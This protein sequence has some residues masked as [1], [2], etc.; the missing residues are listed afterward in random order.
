MLHQAPDTC[1]CGDR[2]H[3]VAH[4]IFIGA[5]VALAAHDDR[6]AL[7]EVGLVRAE[8][9]KEDAPLLGRRDTAGLG[10]AEVEEHDQDPGPLDVAQELVAQALALCCPLHQAGDVGHDELRAVADATDPDDAEVRLQGRERIVGDFRLGG[11]DRRDQRRLA[12]VG[13]SDQGHVGHQL[14]LHVEPELLALLRLLGE[15]GGAAAVRQEPRIA[16]AAL[17]ALCH[18]EAGALDGQVAD[19]GAAA[20]THDRADRNGHDKVLPAGPVPLGTRAVYAV[21]GPTEGVVTESEQRGLVH[22]GHEP[23]VPAVTT[24]APVGATAVHMGLPAPRHRTGPPVPGACVQ[25]GLVDE[26]GHEGPA[27]G[28][29]SEP[30]TQPTRPLPPPDPAIPPTAPG[31]G[32]RATHLEPSTPAVDRGAVSFDDDGRAT[33]PDVGHQI[34]GPRPHQVTEELGI[35]QRRCESGVVGPHTDEIRRPSGLERSHGETQGLST[36]AGG[37]AESRCRAQNVRVARNGAR[38]ERCQPHLVPEMEV[39]VGGRPVGAQADPDPAVEQC[40]QGSDARAELAIGTGAVR[41]GHIVLG[42]QR[43]IRIVEPDCVGG[44]HPAVEDPLGR[45]ERRCAHA[46]TLLD[47]LALG[48]RLRKVDLQQRVARPCLGRNRPHPFWRHRVGGVRTEAHLDELMLPGRGIDHGAGVGQQS[49]PRAPWACV[50]HVED[51]RREHGAD[52]GVNDGINDGRRMP[53]LLA[54]RGDTVAQKLVGPERHAP[55]HVLVPKPRLAWPD[56][57]VQPALERE[58]VPRTPQERHG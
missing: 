21:G 19:D 28:A 38:E 26:A 18:H 57:L 17:T 41:H 51:G 52:S 37:E 50:G 45:Q 36:T 22:R 6:R 27:Y 48:H 30:Q 42:Q 15:G 49:L 1:A 2:E 35:A 32:G 34:A 20:L 5:H 47:D 16:A 40:T 56:G 54:R 53:I 10:R 44:Q 31:V 55:V 23:H 13:E 25:L 11:R 24:V 39:V 7:Q 8:L 46:V 4:A 43:H 12:G 58:P 3:H 14:E 33:D 29:G 9:R